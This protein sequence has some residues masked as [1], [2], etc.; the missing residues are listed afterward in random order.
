LEDVPE[1]QYLLK[2]C[3]EKLDDVVYHI[4]GGVLAT[5]N[6]LISETR[7]FGGEDFQNAVDSFLKTLQSKSHCFT[8]EAELSHQI[9]EIYV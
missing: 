3:N 4:V 5:Y 7:G 2:L 9:W 1:L 6:L 8:G